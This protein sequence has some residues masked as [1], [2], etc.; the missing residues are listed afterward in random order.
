[1]VTIFSNRESQAIEHAVALAEKN[2]NAEIITVV[3][4]SSDYYIP[5]LMLLGFVFGCLIDLF[6]YHYLAITK[7]TH[8]T[9]IQLACMFLLPFFPGLRGGVSY[10]LPKK[11]LHHRAFQLGAEELLFITHKVNSHTPVVLLFVSLAEHYIHIYTNSIVK[12]KIDENKWS[13]L[14]D[15]FTASLKQRTLA[16]ACIETISKISLVLSLIF[17]DD[18]GDNLYS[19][20]VTE[21]PT[22]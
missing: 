12:N 21:G 3:V 9:L 5:E 8:L 18:K 22:T 17:P 13:T 6:I 7:L 10:F 20:K 15:T 16:Q 2:T 14:I 11:L 1:M 19:D 4:P